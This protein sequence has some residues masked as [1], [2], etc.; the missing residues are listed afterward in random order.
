MVDG[1]PVG[2]E[3]ATLV[4]DIS[5]D[6]ALK[7]A[8]LDALHERVAVVDTDGRVLATNTAWLQFAD[9]TSSPPHCQVRV[10]GDYLQ[11]VDQG[12]LGELGATLPGTA[13]AGIRSVM[14]GELPRFQCEYSLRMPGGPA[15]FLMVVTSLHGGCGAVVVAH[16][17]IVSRR[18]VDSE[19]A[20][21]ANLHDELTGLPTG[22]LLRDRLAMSLAQRP[23]DDRRTAVFVVGLE[24]LQLIADDLGETVVD[25]V[26]IEVIRRLQSTVRPGDTVA[27]IGAAQL[28]F[29]C[30]GVRGLPGVEAIRMRLRRILGE[31]FRIKG[32][33]APVWVKTSIGAA[34]DGVDGVEPDGLLLAADVARYVKPLQL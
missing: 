21:A 17:D 1:R 13:G 5:T 28:A 24:D 7:A 19:P 22:V 2:G 15:W 9:R 14:A 4:A 27:R 20:P 33:P 6:A 31:P 23:V 25:E 8:A 11:A 30:S 16:I 26:L 34:L 10:R 29:V 3:V 32:H 18:I 12:A